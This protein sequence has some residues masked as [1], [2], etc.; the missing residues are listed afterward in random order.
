MVSEK[1]RERG[2]IHCHGITR[3]DLSWLEL[4]RTEMGVSTVEKLRD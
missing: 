2:V 4:E 3:M 1:C